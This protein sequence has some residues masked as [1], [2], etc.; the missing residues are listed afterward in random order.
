[1]SAE[2]RAHGVAFYS[3]CS[4]CK[5]AVARAAAKAMRDLLVEDDG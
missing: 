1:M 4:H 2:V 3:V 5:V